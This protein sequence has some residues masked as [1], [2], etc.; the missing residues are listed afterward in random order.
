MTG[1][2]VLIAIDGLRPDAIGPSVSPTL[3]QHIRTG[4]STLRG[5]SVEPSITLPCF[6]SIFHSVPPSEHGVTGNEW[7]PMADPIPGLMEVL[8]GAGLRCSAVYNWEQLR[9]VYRPGQLVHAIYENTNTDPLGD[10]GMANRAVEIIG[11]EE[12]DFLFVYLGV[13]D[14]AGH[15]FGWMSDGYLEQ[16]AR[17]DA[18]AA[19]VLDALPD[20]STV[21][22]IS[23]HGG[24]EFAHGTDSPEDMTIPLIFK[25][26]GIR[27]GYTITE[28]VS[29]LDVS[30]TIAAAFGVDAEPKWRGRAIGEIFER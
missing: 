21:V 6:T 7:R 19:H 26:P 9:D 24:Q 29:L 11:R 25:G 18:A 17:A 13:V 1:P 4:S 5:Q 12:S 10:H 3:V 8:S 14:S 2:V 23:D 28:P 16:V 27:A 22:I 15:E 30:P 20:D